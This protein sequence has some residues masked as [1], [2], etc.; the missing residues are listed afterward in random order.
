MKLSKKELQRKLGVLK[1]A[2]LKQGLEVEISKDG[3]EL[4]FTDKE[5]K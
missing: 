1:R 2:S 3:K 4:V 5:P